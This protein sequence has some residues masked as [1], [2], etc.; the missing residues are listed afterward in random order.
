MIVKIPSIISNNPV[1]AAGVIAVA[2]AWLWIATRGAKKAGQDIG[3]GVVNL[4]FGTVSGAAGAVNENLLDPA[5][6]PYYDLGSSLG[7]TLFN[8]TH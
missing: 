7:E 2:V 4:A 6:N 1:I 3:S 8:W 5:V